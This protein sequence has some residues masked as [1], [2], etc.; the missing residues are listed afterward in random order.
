MELKCAHLRCCLL[1]SRRMQ[2][3]LQVISS[4]RSVEELTNSEPRY[5]LIQLLMRRTALHRLSTHT[6]RGHTF[7][8]SI[9]VSLYMIAFV[10]RLLLIEK[11]D[12][13]ARFV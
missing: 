11:R 8:S 3:C 10:S 6:S 12:C 13:K 7:M 5:R 4:K 9:K 2:N 1:Q